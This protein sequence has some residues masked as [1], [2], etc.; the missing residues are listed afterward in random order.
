MVP[1]FLDLPARCAAVTTITSSSWDVSTVGDSLLDFSL[2]LSSFEVSFD[3]DSFTQSS[4]GSSSKTLFLVT[5]TTITSSSAAFCSPAF[6]SCSSVDSTVVSGR[7]IS[8]GTSEFC[9]PTSLAEMV[10]SLL[11]SKSTVASSSVLSSALVSADSL[12]V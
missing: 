9:S 10:V 1:F 7:S 3:G 5:S 11:P 12:A 6:S 4:A 8:I 2:E